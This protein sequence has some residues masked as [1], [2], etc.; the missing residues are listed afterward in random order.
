MQISSLSQSTAMKNSIANIQSQLADPALKKRF[1]DKLHHYTE[2]CSAYD[3]DEARAEQERMLARCK[4]NRVALYFEKIKNAGPMGF[5]SV[6]LKSILYRL[7]WFK[8]RLR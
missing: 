8:E 2:V 5:L 1:F 3:T 4:K 7:G 6:P